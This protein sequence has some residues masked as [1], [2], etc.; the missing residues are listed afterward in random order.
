MDTKLGRKIRDGIVSQQTGV[1]ITPGMFRGHV[2]LPASIGVVDAGM[3]NR[4]SASK[5]QLFLRE[6]IQQK[7]RVMIQLS[8]ANGIK[9][10]ENRNNFRLPTPPEI[11]SECIELFA[12]TE[13]RRLRRSHRFVFLV[14]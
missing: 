5:F 10:S 12:E 1:S 14:R 8:P 9:I 4:F 11:T 3:Q 6:L 2:L 13:L 7:N